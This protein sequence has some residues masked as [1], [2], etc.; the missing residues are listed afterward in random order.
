VGWI[1]NLSSLVENLA[2][3]RILSGHLA[4]PSLVFEI[5]QRWPTGALLGVVTG[6][7]NPPAVA[8][9]L[10]Q[11]LD[12]FLQGMVAVSFAVGPERWQHLVGA[13]NPW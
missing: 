12:R 2:Y 1:S 4:T 10:V 8:L 6:E 5:A 13:G 3:S 9:A 11:A 7:A